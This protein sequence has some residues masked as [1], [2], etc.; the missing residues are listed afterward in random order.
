MTQASTTQASATSAPS[1][2][3][4]LEWFQDL[5]FGLFIHWGIYANLGG[6]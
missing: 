2:A 4:R 3:Q 6:H 5:R 1:L